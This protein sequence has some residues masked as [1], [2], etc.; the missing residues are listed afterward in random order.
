MNRMR[1]TEFREAMERSRRFLGISED[2]IE[3]SGRKSTLLDHISIRTKGQAEERFLQH[4]EIPS[5][6]P[7]PL[8]RLSIL[9]GDETDYAEIV[10]TRLEAMRGRILGS[11]PLEMDAL[12]SD[13]IISTAV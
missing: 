13:L 5:D 1:R 6:A 3:A 12:P 4:F 8:E 10:H 9:S 11:S 2:Q 7:G